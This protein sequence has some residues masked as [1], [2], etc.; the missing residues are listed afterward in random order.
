MS[1]WLRIAGDPGSTRE[2]RLAALSSLVAEDPSLAPG[3]AAVP[4]PTGE[5]NNHV[6][7][8]YSFSPYTPAMAAWKARAAGLSAAGSVD[9]DSVSA[10]VEMLE[11]CAILG[12]GS[13]VGFEIRVSILDSPFADRKINNPDSLGNA[14]ITVQGLPRSSIPAAAAFLAPI[15]K[16]RGLRNRKTTQAVS[17]ILQDARVEPI[18]YDKD[19]LPL[20]KASEGGSVTER[21]ILAAAALAIFRAWPTGPALLAG[22]KDS[23]R[24]EVPA[25]V[26]SLLA[27][28]S[29]PHKL[30]DL[31]GVLKSAFIDRV[32]VQPGPAE[33]VTARAATAFALSVGA[34][35]AYSYLG[36]VADSP[37]GD[38]KAERFED[39]YLDELI[40]YM[41]DQGFKALT[42]MPPRNTKA[43]LARI[44]NLA[45]RHGLLEI[46]GVDINSSRQ[47]F[48]CP[49]LLEPENHHLIDAT[50][51]LIAHEKLSSLDP[52]YGIFSPANPRAGLPIQ[53]R[54]AAYARIGKALDLTRPEDPT[55]LERLALQGR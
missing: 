48:S 39:A 20:S 10:A 3:G 49:E 52:R 35:P 45:A 15:C 44:R 18:D 32:F 11:A 7:T 12:I 55:L 6:H 30:S 19:V 14:Y 5:V 50:W 37:T 17:A 42:Y 23:L 25:K 36:D 29:N 16:E 27:E 31:I 21:H 46:S 41:V 13:T 26:A 24:I 43:Q 33:C 34:I 28:A 47:S 8:I 53:E 40:P 38:K 51:A 2:G 22:L 9:H 1:D 54:M 4:R